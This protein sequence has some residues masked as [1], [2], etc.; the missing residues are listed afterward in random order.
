MHSCRAA[1]PLAFVPKKVLILTI[2]RLNLAGC[3][4]SPGGVLPAWCGVRGVA[5][6]GGAQHRCTLKPLPPHAHLGR[7]DLA[8]KHNWWGVRIPASREEGARGR[9][10]VRFDWP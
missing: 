2:N 4:S 9:R 8:H 7:T 5:C 10:G 1:P 3:H 6:M